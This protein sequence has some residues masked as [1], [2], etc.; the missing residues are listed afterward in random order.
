MTESLKRHGKTIG[1]VPT[2]GYFHEGHLSLFRRARRE[3]DV[4]VV[5]LFVNPAQF[6]VNEDFKQYPRNR[7]RDMRL[8]AQE[9]VDYV[10]APSITAM[11]PE[12]FQTYVE[13]GKLA[14]G[15]CGKSRP[16]HFRGV[17]TVV[18]KLFNLAQPTVVYLGQKDYQQCLIIRQ[19]VA[20]FDFQVQIKMCPIVR[21]PS[22]LALSSRNTYLDEK[23]KQKALALVKAI[24]WFQARVKKGERDARLLKNGVRRILFKA[25]TRVD[26]V[27]ILAARELSPFRKLSGKILLAL[28]AYV[29]AGKRGGARNKVRLI[30]NCVM[31]IPKGG[32]I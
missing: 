16:G 23:G 22:G 14:S 28:A 12:G 20:D 5:S 25:G 30:D 6:G 18:A 15:L 27:E 4:V 3:N 2:M 10:F 24:R 17:A 11:Y 7:K 32:F 31:K 13:P 21:E 8:C 26:Y 29:P 19:L 9:R 1:F